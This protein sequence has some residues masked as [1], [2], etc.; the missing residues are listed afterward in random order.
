MDRVIFVGGGH[1][2]SGTDLM[3]KLLCSHSQ[4]AWIAK[5]DTFIMEAVADLLPYLG[6]ESSTYLPRCTSMKYVKFREHIG[7]HFGISAGVRA[8]LDRLEAKISRS[9]VYV[10]RFGSL[11]LVEP[12]VPQEIT[13]VMA[14]FLHDLLAAAMTNPRA[15][16]GCERTPSNAQYIGLAYAVLPSSKMV[17]VNR[18]PIDLA[19]S[20][21][22]LDWGPDDA[23]EAA[24]Y[25]HAYLS[26]WLTVRS[27]VPSSYYLA[28]KFEALVAAPHDTL[29]QVFAFLDIPIEPIV[30]DAADM[31]ISGV[32]DRRDTVSPAVLVSMRSVLAEDCRDLGYECS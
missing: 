7:R 3:R 22:P 32:E 10:P 14:S 5:R 27:R 1:G 31:M 28:V 21:L 16:Y 19:L 26:R 2:R 25:T 23:M 15:H 12:L 17:V 11:P 8:A 18:N 30:L 20:L 9:T 29:R 6:R 24:R 4:V 13:D